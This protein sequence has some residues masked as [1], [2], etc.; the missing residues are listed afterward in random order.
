MPTSGRPVVFS[1]AGTT[2]CAARRQMKRLGT[3]PRK[4]G[5]K[6][7]VWLRKATTRRFAQGSGGVS[8]LKC[9]SCRKKIRL[10]Y[11]SE[12]SSENTATL[13]KKPTARESSRD[14]QREKPL[15]ERRTLS[16]V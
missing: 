12:T 9:I 1:A 4:T 11:L 14:S 13:R 5:S 2:P 8:P 3:P 6:R 10:R 7:E 16:L 15:R